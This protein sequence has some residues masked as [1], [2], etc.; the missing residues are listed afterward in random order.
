MA[1][2]LE[3]IGIP[4]CE[5]KQNESSKKKGTL[6][7][8]SSPEDMDGIV[9]GFD[10]Y[11][12]QNTRGK[13]YHFEVAVNTETERQIIYVAGASGSGKSYW[14][15][16]YVDAYQKC[17]PKN[18]IYLFSSI[19]EDSSIDKIKG[20]NRIRISESLVADELGA[21]DFENCCVIFDDVDTLSNSKLRKAVMKIQ[22]DILQCGR[23]Y[24]TTALITSHVATNGKDT[25]L[26]LGEAHIITFFP[27][28][29]PQRSL[30]YLL[31]SYMG[32]DKEQISKVKNLPGR[33]VSYIKGFPRCLVSD[34]EV[35]VLKMK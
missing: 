32:L 22:D 13:D 30:K 1:L 3:H 4:I 21:K 20:L 16:R 9:H 5:I 28:M 26:I 19:S 34:K 7:S 31:E 12:L 27:A 8:L 17:Y 25:R 10:E 33:S 6:I 11:S 29:M 2:N 18:E 35:M 14:C 23:H 15:K 24:K